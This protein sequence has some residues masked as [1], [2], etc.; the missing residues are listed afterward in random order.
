MYR[1]IF[2][3]LRE[4]RALIEC[5][6]LSKPEKEVDPMNKIHRYVEF[7]TYD[8]G[9]GSEFESQYAALTRTV[10]TVDCQM[11]EAW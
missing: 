1:Y 3:A 5:P 2:V 10:K 9:H 8:V 11:C 4:K 7:R 6:S